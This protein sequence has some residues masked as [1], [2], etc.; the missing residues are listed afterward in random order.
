MVYEERA[1]RVAY[2]GDVRLNQ[3]D[4]ATRSP[5]ATL[6]L[7]A[8]GGGIETLVAGEPVEVRQG[9]RTATGTRGTYTPA[10]QKMVLVGD[11]VILRDPSQQIQGQTLT[12]HVGDERIFVDGQ[13][14][15]TQTILKREPPKP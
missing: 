12:F 3:G 5:E 4:I 13:E 6:V 11:N 15:R 1:S 7:T 10:E 14:A 2:A 8:D 9:N